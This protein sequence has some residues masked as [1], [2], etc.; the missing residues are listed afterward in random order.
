MAAHRLYG[1]KWAM[2]ARLFP[3]RIDNA[4]KYKRCYKPCAKIV[5]GVATANLV[6]ANAAKAVSIEN[7]MVEDSI[8]EACP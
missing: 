7:I 1:N 3:G 8:Q 2:I 5:N 4:V 6:V